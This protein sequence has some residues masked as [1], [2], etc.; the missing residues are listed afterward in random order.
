MRRA[1]VERPLRELRAGGRD[2]LDHLQQLARAE[3]ELGIADAH[4]AQ[5]RD[6]IQ[7]GPSVLALVGHAEPQ[8]VA[9]EV[10]RRL[11]ARDRNARVID[12]AN[13][14]AR[15][16]SGTT[17]RA[18]TSSIVSARRTIS[19]SLPLTSAIAGLGKRIEVG[20]AGIL[21]GTGVEEG[22]RVAKLH[23]G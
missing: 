5:A 19:A 10:Q 17:S 4:A 2:R 13:G 3:I 16:R 11:E 21:V 20:C 15:S 22:E 8:Q 14:H 23:G 12:A 6:R 9:V 1:R 7:L 18:K